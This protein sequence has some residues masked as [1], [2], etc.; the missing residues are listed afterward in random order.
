M[1]PRAAR[2]ETEEA[3]ARD[4][5]AVGR[6]AE[7]VVVGDDGFFLR[8]SC[9]VSVVPVLVS[10]SEDGSGEDSEHDQGEEEV[11]HCVEAVKGE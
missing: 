7:L 11:L 2:S 5:R 4:D 9:A 8:G 1:L 10:H 6:L 3:T